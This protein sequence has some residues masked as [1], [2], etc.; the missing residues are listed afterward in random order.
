[1]NSRRFDCICAGI[2]VADHVCDPID[3]MP[4]AGELITTDRLQLTI[5]GC[6]SNAA[7]DLAKLGVNVGI[8]GI[9][10]RDVFGSYVREFLQAAGVN[11]DSLLESESQQTSSTLVVNVQGEDRRFIHTIGANAEFNGSEV[12]PELIDGCRVLYL[13][14]YCISENPTADSVAALFAAARKAGVITVLDVV[15]PAPGDYLSRLR[16][17]LPHTG[18]FLPNNDEAHL[19]TGI[20]DPL[21]QAQAFREAGAK[22]VVITC[23]GDGA[24]LVGDDVRLRAGTD[25]VQFVDG[26]GSGDAFVAGYI[27]GL[28]D[29]KDA[30]EC[31]RIGSA[32]GASCVRKIGATSGVFTANELSEFITS[33]E[34]QIQNV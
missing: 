4:A 20:S 1:M 11:C 18:V 21:A 15:I 31:L 28:L 19:I 33:T 22:T 14:G 6:A 23:G 32:L 2:V 3:H 8:V 17:V 24:V 30:R 10:G 12:T 13:G 25:Q 16:P 5:G 26:T 29:G 34:L 9:V 27:H 7:V